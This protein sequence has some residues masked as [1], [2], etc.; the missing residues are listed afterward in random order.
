MMSESIGTLYS[1]YGHLY[2]TRI[3][4]AA[5]VAG[6][7]IDLADQYTDTLGPWIYKYG[8]VYISHPFMRRYS[9]P[10]RATRCTVCIL[11]MISLS[12]VVS[13]IITTFRRLKLLYRLVMP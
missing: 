11:T 8:T 3:F 13:Q 4:A 12:V 1:W 7:K 2:S 10:Q 9:N 6:I 5:A